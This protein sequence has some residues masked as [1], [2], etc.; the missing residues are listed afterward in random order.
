MNS[1]HNSNSINAD[2]YDKRLIRAGA[3]KISITEKLPPSYLSREAFNTIKVERLME[4][5]LQ[6]F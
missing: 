5:H 4:I 6:L 2:S 1:E 3:H